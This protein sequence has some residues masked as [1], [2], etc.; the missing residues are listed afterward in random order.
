M[1]RRTQNNSRNRNDCTCGCACAEAAEME[2]HVTFTLANEM[3]PTTLRKRSKSRGRR[4]DASRGDTK[5]RR[6]ATFGED[7]DATYEDSAFDPK[8]HGSITEE[9]FNDS[10]QQHQ[11]STR[12]QTRSPIS[13]RV[14]NVRRN[15]MSEFASPRHE[16]HE[17][18]DD[19]SVNE[20]LLDL[21]DEPLSVPH[22]GY[23][24]RVNSFR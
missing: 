5:I 24:Y 19:E 16:L 4:K 10:T 21:E 14:E 7:Y 20:S 9:T 17:L 23:I 1:N 8:F 2:R 12:S 13:P 11:I 15:L 18:L 6:N 3:R 22:L